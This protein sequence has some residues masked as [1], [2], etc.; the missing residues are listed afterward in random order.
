MDS[1]CIALSLSESWT[2]NTVWTPILRLTSSKTNWGIGV[3]SWRIVHLDTRCQLKFQP[4]AA[5]QK[6]DP[7]LTTQTGS[8]VD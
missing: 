4:A 3:T 6:R 5:F 7:S 8:R 1:N 2:M